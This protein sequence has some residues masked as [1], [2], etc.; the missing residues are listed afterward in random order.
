M[1]KIKQIHIDIFD[2]KE[3]QNQEMYRWK[4]HNGCYVTVRTNWSW[5]I[6]PWKKQIDFIIGKHVVLNEPLNKNIFEQNQKIDLNKQFTSLNSNSSNA[7][8][9]KLNLNTNQLKQQ[10]DAHILNVNTNNSNNNNN[11]SSSMGINSENSHNDKSSSNLST[12][13]SNED[14]SVTD[15]MNKIEKDIIEYISRVGITFF[16]AHFY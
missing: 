11:N 10:K 14:E 4:C 7:T 5:F 3:R 9:S 6:H 12:S 1:N 8:T 16:K 13:V 2:G 15:Y